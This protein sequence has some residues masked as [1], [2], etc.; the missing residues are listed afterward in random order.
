MVLLE[1]IER[2]TRLLSASNYVT[3]GDVRSVFLGLQEHLIQYVNNQD[4]SQHA[5]AQLIYQK[6]TDYWPIL[7]KSSQ[8]S[9]LLDLR[10]KLSA[11]KNDSEIEEVK[12]LILGLNGYSSTSASTL[13]STTISTN[14]IISARNYFRQ[15]RGGVNNNNNTSTS[16]TINI[17]G[18][19]TRYLAMPLEDQ[20]DPLIW[21]QAQQ[22]GF[23]ILSQIVRNYLCIQ[24]TNVASEQAFS[25]AGQTI[26]PL[27]N[28]LE[29]E[30]AR[31]TLC[32]KSWFR[33]NIL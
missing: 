26:S 25:I 28:R 20:I 5:M 32:L 1:L 27:R 21:W 22:Q 9:S 24:A 19:L 6:L 31:A 17:Q 23:P 12:D 4:F 14:D 3:H 29:A 15:L 11:F 10:V 8:I 7:D 33:Q 16:L 13:A 18:E 2:A 30:T